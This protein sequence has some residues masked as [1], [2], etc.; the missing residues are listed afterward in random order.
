MYN[1]LLK[2]EANICG[3]LSPGQIENGVKYGEKNKKKFFYKYF[4]SLIVPAFMLSKQAVAQGM[5]SCTK[6]EN[7]PV[8]KKKLPLFS[9][10]RTFEFSGTIVDAE[11]RN[12]I[13]Q[14][15]ITITQSRIGIVG[16]DDGMFVL[17]NSIDN[18]SVSLQISAIGYETRQLSIAIPS[19]DFKMEGLIIDLKQRQILL[20]NISLKAVEGTN[21]LTGSVGNMSFG[22][23]ISKLNTLKELPK[24]IETALNDSIKI[25]P[26]PTKNV[27]NIQ[28][29]SF[30]IKTATIYD[31]T[32]R[33]VLASQVSNQAIDVHSLSTGTYI[34]S[35]TDIEGK[36]HIQKFIKNYRVLLY[37]KSL[38]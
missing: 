4:I 19:E 17:R 34:L 31:I 28:S 20:D 27:L 7:T 14:S 21:Y 18:D 22:I 6:I 35:L 2:N 5:V 9:F 33:V 37:K 26:N 24:R 38:Q 29:S 36:N 1:T 30:E 13:P 10:K 25:Y 15:S 3:R 11:T 32:G 16:D 8:K 12:V 23:R